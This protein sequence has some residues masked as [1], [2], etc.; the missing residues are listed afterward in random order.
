MLL[1]GGTTETID[2]NQMCKH[3][4][5]LLLQAN[6]K[7]LDEVDEYFCLPTTPHTT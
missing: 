5:K 6:Q 1:K 7:R 4:V 2:I 3:K